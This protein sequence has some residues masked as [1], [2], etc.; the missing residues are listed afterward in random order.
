MDQDDK[1]KKLEEE[2]KQRDD[3]IKAIVGQTRSTQDD[4]RMIEEKLEQ[5]QNRIQIANTELNVRKRKLNDLTNQLKA[6]GQEKN[7][8]LEDSSEENDDERVEQ[9]LKIKL[10]KMISNRQEN[11]TDPNE[12]FFY[13]GQRSEVKSNIAIHTVKIKLVQSESQSSQKTFSKI[14]PRDC[15]FRIHKTMNFIH[16]KDKACEHWVISS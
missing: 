1:K 6:K 15:T 11:D 12:L 10:L 2:I 8:E 5:L 4:I 13:D 16:L 9:E 14:I 7:E 3:D